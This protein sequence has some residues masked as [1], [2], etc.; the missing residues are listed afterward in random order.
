MQT[1]NNKKTTQTNLS[2]ELILMSRLEV[3]KVLKCS[4]STVKRYQSEGKLPPIYLT[5]RLV[6]YRQADLLNLIKIC[7]A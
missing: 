5:K 2:S 7:A 1:T 6:R 3:T 4:I